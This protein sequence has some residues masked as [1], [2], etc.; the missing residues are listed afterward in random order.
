MCDDDC[1]PQPGWLEDFLR[2]FRADG[3]LALVGGKI[4]NVGFEGASVAKGIGGFG[5][6]GQIVLNVP[7]E[8]AGYFGCANLGLR[9]DQALQA[10]GF[11]PFLVCGYEEGDLA[12]SLQR[13]G[14][15]IAYAPG[16]MVEHHNVSATQR[17]RWRWMHTGVMRVYFYLK[18]FRPSG[19]G[20][21]RFLAWECR[22]QFHSL[23]KRGNMS[24]YRRMFGILTTFCLLPKVTVISG[25][26]RRRL[27][28]RARNLD[29]GT[30]QR[31]LM[32][33]LP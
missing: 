10:G 3:S 18:H 2:C 14:Y 33:C 4:V 28:D 31:R 15:R 20:W 7:V 19:W 12:Q 23:L 5:R 22:L 11:D 6:N 8:Q 21:F 17:S 24:L 32:T 29:V 16:A 1:L 9:R 26:A 30:S 25:H 13:L 27:L